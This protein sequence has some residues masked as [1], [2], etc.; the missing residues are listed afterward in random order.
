VNPDLELEKLAIYLQV[1]RSRLCH[2]KV[3]GYGLG[4]QEGCGDT[5]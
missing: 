4:I 2:T 1:Y 3:I 5:D